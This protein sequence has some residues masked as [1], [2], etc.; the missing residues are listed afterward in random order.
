MIFG[1]VPSTTPKIRKLKGFLFGALLPK[2]T[3]PWQE[4]AE[5][6]FSVTVKVPKSPAGMFAARP[7]V[8]VN[9]LGTRSPEVTSALTPLL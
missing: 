3:S 1:A 6:A 2:L 8:T 9:P 4:P 7:S 5:V